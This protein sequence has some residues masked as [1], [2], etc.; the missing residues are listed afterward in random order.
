MKS[1]IILYIIYGMDSIGRYL[2]KM[3]SGDILSLLCVN[4]ML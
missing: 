2:M 1:T 4:I 3:F